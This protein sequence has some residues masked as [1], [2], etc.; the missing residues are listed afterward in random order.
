MNR[1]LVV[2]DEAGICITLKKFL[3]DD[4]YHVE[5][6]ESYEE[7]EALLRTNK[8]N[9][10]FADMLLK[11]KSG[12][13]VLKF[14]KRR[15][16]NCQVVM[17]T[18]VP[19]IDTVAEALRLGAFDYIPKP[20]TKSILLRA[21]GIACRYS[22]LLEQ[23]ETY[24]R[25]LDAIFKGTSDAILM[26]DREMIIT[27]ANDKIRSICKIN[28][29]DIIGS[30]FPDICS[31]CCKACEKLIRDTIE[32]QYP[33]EVHRAECF[34]GEKSK[35]A[36]MM[37]TSPLFDM[38]DSFIGIV[39]MIRDVSRLSM[40]EDQLEEC[41]RFDSIVGKS[42]QIQAIYTLIE[43]LADIDANVLITGESG[44][45]KELVAEAIHQKGI[46]KDYPFITVNCSALPDTLLGSELFG[47]VKGA[48]T[49]A[50][51]TRIGRF[52]AAAGGTLFLDEIGDISPAVQADLLRVIQNKEITRLGE[53]TPVKVDTRIIAATN[54]DL[55]KL[56]KKGAF[57]E[58][59]YYRLNVVE[60]RV[61]SLRERRDDI[62]LLT[63]YFV[64]KNGAKLN[65]CRS[66]VA[67]DVI[68]LFMEY[69]W[70]GN[71][72]ELEHAIEHALI[73]G[74]S[75][76]MSIDDLPSELVEFAKNKSEHASTLV[77]EDDRIKILRALEQSQW[78]K[79]KA[80]ELLGISRKTLYR[81]ME[82]LD[83][84]IDA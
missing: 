80:A 63:N 82:K 44:T 15:Q 79:S 54:R 77:E 20:I 30:R 60:V 28:S 83:K 16:R 9:V 70:P 8:Y 11:E 33:M 10:V 39:V 81:K 6:A 45:G 12:I 25:N 22:E 19:Q 67:N 73:T 1:I 21:T 23:K 32:K 49:G 48:F 61:P 84:Q 27:E 51:I 69:P 76:S 3:S 41:I 34:S 7:A 72:R 26:L 68:R 56:I 38:D 5:T 50:H 75:C 66:T 71:I 24:R 47:H 42:R 14:I 62:P 31:C 57:R 35:R 37:L 40:L 2:D 52:E 18:G 64:E 53:T 58:D 13:D 78:N 65:N 74:N 29:D 4:G 59:L 17:I 36:F 46:R 43:K 55:R